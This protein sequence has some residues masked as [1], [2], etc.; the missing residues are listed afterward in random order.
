MAIEIA[1]PKV[2]KQ[3]GSAIAKAFKLLIKK[4]KEQRKKQKA[5]S[6][7]GRGKLLNK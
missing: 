5:D 4:V 3:A 7:K 1:K 2:Q 6:K